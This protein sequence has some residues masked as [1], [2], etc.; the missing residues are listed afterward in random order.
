M[1]PFRYGCIV[2]GS[3]FCDRPELAGR[4]AEYVRSGQNLVIQ[5]ER[6]MG[7]SSLVTNTLAQMKGWRY[8]YADFMDVRSTADVCNQLADAM[9]RFEAEDSIFK[10]TLSLLAH[11]RPT[12]TV[13]A[14]TGM[15]TI[16][17]DAQAAA[18]ASSVTTAL[19]ALSELVRG[20]KTCVVLDEFQ[21]ILKVKDG[22]R[23]LALMRSRIQ[24]LADT[25]FVFL[26]SA[27]NDMLDIFLSP[28]SPFY[29]SAT[30]FDVG[31]IDDAAFYD[32]IKKRFSTGRR[33][34]PREEFDAILEFTNR[35]PG[36]VQEYC[37]AI[38]QVTEVRQR[39][40]PS[41]R[42]QALQHVFAREGA[43]FSSFSRRL[44]DIQFRVARALSVCGGHHPLSGEFLREASVSNS[45][46]VKRALNAL[47]A[48]GLVCQ[49]GGEYKF[50]SPFF[51]D[52]IRRTRR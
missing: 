28:K 6:R 21:D 52:W 44:T 46:T 32:F 14:M 25:P 9:A 24:F 41:V 23:V 4:L 42:E 34:L 3:H 13:D 17:V 22:S 39:I 29:K 2:N 10:R 51:R 8:V 31:T 33:Q 26:G 16:T 20:G 15:P 30:V 36:D 5:G 48:D 43:A 1:N 7:K 40:T 11:L 12:V 18:G 37:D 19:N 27:R 49:L 50:I 47:I 35:T 38:W 45:A